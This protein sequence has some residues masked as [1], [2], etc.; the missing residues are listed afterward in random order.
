MT[1]GLFY[2][3]KGKTSR[4]VDILEPCKSS[5]SLPGASGP[6]AIVKTTHTACLHTDMTAPLE[7][8]R[9]TSLIDYACLWKTMN[10]EPTNLQKVKSV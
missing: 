10:V 1:D 9:L 2:K 5:S 6:A 7:R 8:L 3:Q 4:V